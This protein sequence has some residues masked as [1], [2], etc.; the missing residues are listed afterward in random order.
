MDH[1]FQKYRAMVSV[2]KIF[3]AGR[4]I[5]FLGRIKKNGSLEHA[6]LQCANYLAAL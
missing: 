1:K 6:M 5:I 4:L 3:E 2:F